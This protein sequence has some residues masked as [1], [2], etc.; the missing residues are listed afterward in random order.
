MRPLARGLVRQCCMGV[1]ILVGFKG[2]VDTVI[3]EACTF[4][5]EKGR[6]CVCKSK[7]LYDGKNLCDRH[8]AYVK[9]REPCSIC[10]EPM[11]RTGERIQLSCGHFFHMGCL[12]Q[13]K[14]PLCPYCRAPM[15]PMEACKVF[16]ETK[17]RPLMERVYG[18][19]NPHMALGLLDKLMRVIERNQDD[20]GWKMDSLRDAIGAFDRCMRACDN[21]AVDMNDTPQNMIRDIVNVLTGLRT[22]LMDFGTFSGFVVDGA[23]GMLMA[24]SIT[25][26]T[27]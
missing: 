22:H 27:E 7:H 14:T 20:D 4:V 2:V 23:D 3:M 9:S 11:A 15:E 25:P 13:C 19:R 10:L 21:V 18:M 5:N 6:G 16:H 24:T 12:S 8:L 17:V 1:Y 26:F